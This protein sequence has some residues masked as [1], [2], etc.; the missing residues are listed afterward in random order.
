M[1]H[2]IWY[3]LSKLHTHSK[4]HLQS[5]KSIEDLELQMIGRAISHLPEH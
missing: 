1:G 2:Q 4:I 5:V 3:Q